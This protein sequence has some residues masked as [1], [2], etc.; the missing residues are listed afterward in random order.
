M[1]IVITSSFLSNLNSPWKTS[2]ATA[3][4][5]YGSKSVQWTK[6][7]V[8]SLEVNAK[9]SEKHDGTFFLFR[10]ICIHLFSFS[11]SGV[12]HWIRCYEVVKKCILYGENS[13]FRFCFSI[14]HPSIFLLCFNIL[15]LSIFQFCFSILVPSILCFFFSILGPSIFLFYFSILHLSINWLIRQVLPS[16]Q[17]V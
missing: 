11:S 2:H 9:G 14:L 16:L 1:P 7:C 12:L 4:V 5:T 13:F 8:L 15:N 6:P 17:T 10:W 3:I